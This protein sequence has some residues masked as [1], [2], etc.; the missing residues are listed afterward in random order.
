[1]LRLRA[2][3]TKGKTVN[4]LPFFAL[5]ISSALAVPGDRA[6]WEVIQETPVP[7]SCTTLA[8]TPWCRS[9]GVVHAPVGDVVEALRNMRYNA[10]SFESV[11]RIDVVDD[12]VLHIVLDYPSPLSDRDYVAEY[13]YRVEGDAHIYSWKPANSRYPEVE[14]IVR[15]PNFAGEWRLEPRG[16]RTWVRYTWHAQINGSFPSF[17]YKTAWKK[18]GHEALKDLAQTQK[19]KLTIR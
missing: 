15:L 6:S 5:L 1:M 3:G 2:K 7:V 18:A 19:A 4:L 13:T 9:E 8:S 10:S 11:V 12:D 16:N 14:D 17:G